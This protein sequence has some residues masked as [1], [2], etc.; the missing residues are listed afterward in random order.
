MS[1]IGL[2]YNFAGQQ[3][4]PVRIWAVR[5]AAVLGA[6]MAFA[7]LLSWWLPESPDAQAQQQNRRQRQQTTQAPSAPSAAPAAP[8]AAAGQ[9]GVRQFDDWIL[10]CERPQGAARDTCSLRQTLAQQDA[11]KHVLWSV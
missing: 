6:V 11:E 7:L 10:Q 9:P 8:T 4:S 2:K 1:Q 3:R 5:I